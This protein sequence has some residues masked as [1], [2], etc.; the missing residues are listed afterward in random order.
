MQPA[1]TPPSLRNPGPSWGYSFLLWAERWWPRWFFRPVLMAGTWIGLACMPARRAHSR[2]YLT[3]V[4][5][6]TPTLVDLWRHFFAFAEFLILKL[7]T[8]RGVPLPRTLAP[9][10]AGPF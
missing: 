5:G 1:T 2:T 10:N 3:L 8:G 9:E 4:L 6:R 7:R